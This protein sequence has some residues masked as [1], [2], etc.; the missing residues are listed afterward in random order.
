MKIFRFIAPTN[1]SAWL[2]LIAVSLIAGAANAGV[3]MI[4][5]FA[6]RSAYGTS[7]NFYLFFVFVLTVAVYYVAQRMAFAMVASDVEATVH[8]T[9]LRILSLV[10]RCELI[11]IE[12]MG[13][14]RILSAMTAEAQGLSQAMSQVTAGLQSV[15]V[16]I[17]TGAYIAWLSRPAFLLWLF[18]VAASSVLILREWSTS[19]RLLGEA[20]AKDGLFQSTTSSLLQGFKEVKL[21]RRRADALFAELT[22]LAGEARD[23]RTTAQHGMSRSY[24]FGQV[25]FF[26]L[27]GSMVFLLP[28]LGNI[29]ADTLKEATTAVLFVLGPVS[30]IIGAIPALS[31][32]ES[33]ATGLVAL[34]DALVAQVAAE[35]GEDAA[36]RREPRGGTFQSLD[37]S[38]IMFSYPNGKRGSLDLA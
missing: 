18:V 11:G 32:A 1:D 19:Q 4:V 14:A 24:V 37:L 6:A 36:S 8:R 29:T 27:V 33:A 2:R 9:R 13:E 3:L 17:M 25:L 12:A 15:L 21:N 34:E 5:S 28:A 10:R 23:I 38:G 35:G 16:A 20:G 30:M 26:L 31:S 22:T 7:S